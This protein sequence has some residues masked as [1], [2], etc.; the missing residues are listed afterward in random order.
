MPLVR[1][2][3][4]EALGEARTARLTSGGEAATNAQGSLLWRGLSLALNART[5]LSCQ[6]GHRQVCN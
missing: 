1:P 3:A 2:L 5:N 4:I 6:P